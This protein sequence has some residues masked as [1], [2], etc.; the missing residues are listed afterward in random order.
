MTSGYLLVSFAF[1]SGLGWAAF[2]IAEAL[3]YL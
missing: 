1:A 2:R 3:G